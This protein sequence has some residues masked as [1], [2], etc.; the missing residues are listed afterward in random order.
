[1]AATVGP[2]ADGDAAPLVR[3]LVPTVPADL[4]GDGAQGLLDIDL[5]SFAHVLQ[6]EVNRIEVQSA[7]DLVQLSL[8]GEAGLRTAGR[9]VGTGWRLV[10]RHIVAV[11]LDVRDAVNAADPRRCPGAISLDPNI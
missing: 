11:V 2:F 8:G 4:S 6:A 5:G 7:R 10:G 9:A 1:R 3:A